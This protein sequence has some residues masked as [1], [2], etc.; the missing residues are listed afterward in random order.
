MTALKHAGEWPAYDPE[1]TPA[2]VEQSERY[3][4]TLSPGDVISDA[5]G[6]VEHAWA[7]LHLIP[8]ALMKR[9]MHLE[10]AVGGFRVRR[11]PQAVCNAGYHQAVKRDRAV[12]RSLTVPMGVQVIDDFRLELGRC[13]HCMTTL[14][15][16]A[17]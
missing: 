17:E 4:A 10:A 14:A 16:E 13:P 11:A 2:L 3:A 1:T 8:A 9:G 5:A 15:V 7:Y 12:F 6:D